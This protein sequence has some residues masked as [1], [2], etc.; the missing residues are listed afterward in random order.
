MN[1]IDS[2]N[3]HIIQIDTDILEMKEICKGNVKSIE[4][5]HANL[6]KYESDLCELRDYI[7]E[8]NTN[9]KLLLDD[10]KLI[11]N[12]LNLLKIGDL[13]ILHQLINALLDEMEKIK[14]NTQFI[15]SKKHWWSK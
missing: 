6:R 4:G 15:K 14:G 1:I 9:T 13:D 5:Y 2:L 7:N 8:V 11:K 12:E 3:Q 10:T